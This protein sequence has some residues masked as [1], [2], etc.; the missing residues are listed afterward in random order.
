MKE[1][2]KKIIFQKRRQV[3]GGFV[4]SL[5]ETIVMEAGLTLK[6]FKKLPSL[7]RNVIMLHINR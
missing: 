6:L 1:I 3:A 5:G 2:S 4:G 7:Y